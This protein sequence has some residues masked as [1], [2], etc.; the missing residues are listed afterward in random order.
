MN[1]RVLTVLAGSAVLSVPALARDLDM[2]KDRDSRI[3]VYHTLFG[4]RYG[5]P[6]YN[7]TLPGGHQ[8]KIPGGIHWW[9]DFS[10]EQD[11]LVAAVN[12]RTTTGLAMV[13]G[14]PGNYGMA[15]LAQAVSFLAPLAGGRISIPDMTNSFFDVF[16][17]VDLDDYV[18]SG[19]ATQSLP[20]GMPLQFQNGV[21]VQNPSIHAGLAAFAFNPAVGWVTPQP[22]NGQLQVFGQIGLTPKGC[23]ANC[24]ASTTPPVLN[25]GDFGCFLNRYAAGDPE[26]NCDGSTTPP[27]LNV[28]DFGCFLNEFA[29]GCG[30]R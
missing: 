18:Q 14:G 24:D 9:T 3:T 28:L 25:V 6:A 5:D 17:A 20:I 10:I 29:R 4:S 27:T 15:D 26:V 21:C 8:L 12:R 13:T 1:A 19:W 22:L 30:G 11:Y 23:F 7:G 16:V 2:T